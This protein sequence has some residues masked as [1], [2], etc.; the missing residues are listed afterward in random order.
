M[1]LGILALLACQ[2]Q[3]RGGDAKKSGGEA[4]PARAAASISGE[5]R[6]KGRE[7]AGGT[8]VYIPGTSLSSITD[9]AGHYLL[10]GVAPGE[11]EVYGR[12]EGYQTG[13]LGKITVAAAEG[14]KP[15]TLPPATL[16]P[17]DAARSPGA[18][19]ESPKAGAIRGWLM[20]DPPEAVDWSQATIELE[21]TPYRTVAATSGTFLLWSLPPDQYQMTA[22]MPGF[23]PAT[24]AVRVLPGPE[25]TSV[26]VT[27]TALGG[28]GGAGGGTGTGSYLYV[29]PPTPAGAGAAGALTTATTARIHGLALKNQEGI[30]DMSGISVALTGTTRIATTDGQG[31][32]DIG[33]IKPGTYRLLA[34][35]EGFLPAELNLELRAGENREL[36][37]IL[38]EPRRIYPVVLQTTPGDGARKV[39][40]VPEITLMVRFNKKM[41][42]D[43][44]R[45]AVSVEPAVAFRV[46]AGREAPDTDF[47][48]MKVLIY[49]AIQ[50][51]IARF[52]TRYTLTIGQAAT[53][54]EGLTLQETYRTSFTTGDAEVIRTLPVNGSAAVGLSPQLPVTIFFN[55]PIDNRTL[56][57]EAVAV[58]PKPDLAPLM[59][60]HDDEDTGWSRLS[61]TGMWRPDTE[62]RITLLRRLRTAGDQAITNTPYTFRFRTAKLMV[63]RIPVPPRGVQQ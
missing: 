3:D 39:A 62:Y 32:Y 24:A 33:E 23:E 36:D 2:E 43:S 59:S 38:L 53:D 19:A 22:R 46:V 45:Q 52:R 35:A 4:A 54:V 58:Q 31:Q 50:K 34:Q 8:Q 29:S 57:Q 1:A 56:T 63:P 44:L 13:L 10:D 37:A 47:D 28:G 9:R 25:A 40:V 12:A 18:A 26:T 7:D 55:A 61:I 14:A 5:V 42:P 48:L 27:L 16:E 21:K 51:P 6:L 20:S 11:Y 49:G 41:N 30:S 60:L 15:Y 17:R